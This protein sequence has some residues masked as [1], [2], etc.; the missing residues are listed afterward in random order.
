MRAVDFSS[1]VAMMARP[2]VRTLVASAA[3]AAVAL[4]ASAQDSKRCA[5]MTSRHVANATIASATEI[6]PGSFSADG[7][8]VTVAAAA[9]RVALTLRPSADSDIKVEVW[10]PLRGWNG[11]LQAVGNGAFNGS[12]AYPAMAD[13]LSRGYAAASTDTGHAGNSAEFALGHPEKLVDFGYRAVHEMTVAAKQVV[14]AFY[15]APARYAYWN[16]CSAGGRQGLQEAQRYPA[17]F[18]GIIA[19]AP[20]IDWIGRAARA[21]QVAQRTEADPAARLGAAERALLHEAVVA[22]CDAQDGVT[23]GLIARPDRCTFDPGVL[24]CKA[25]ASSSCLTPSQVATARLMYST[26]TNARTKREI[27]GV[28]RGSELGWTDLGWTASAQNTGLNLF[29]FVVRQNAGWA[30]RDF[31]LDV[32]LPLAEEKDQNTMNALN[33]DLGPFFMR[34]GKLIHYHGLSD[35][36]ISPWNSTQ[37][38]DTVVRTVGS[39]EVVAASHRLFLAPG[40]GHCGGG[41][42]PNTFDMISAL[43]QWVEHG[44][45]PDKLIASHVTNGTV[46]RTRPLCPYPQ[47]G[48]YTGRGSP[49]DAANFAC[50]L[51]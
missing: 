45:A 11:K 24:E 8:S 7:A 28:A 26:V 36:Q 39:R 23:D 1:S 22:A 10:L 4:T 5:S 3:C 37:Y 31:K 40:M 16:G 20:G 44:A 34:G 13:A 47:I 19:G 9:C 2:I 17:D 12:I 15:D 51:P 6:S 29:R 43:E 27:G 50:R 33:P 18:D 25:G 32:D 46:D 42:G 48:I 41:E 35:P 21:V 14:A 49:D 38:Y 30:L